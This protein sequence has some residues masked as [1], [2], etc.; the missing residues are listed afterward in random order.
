[1]KLQCRERVRSDL[2]SPARI[3]TPRERERELLGVGVRFG[4]FTELG[5][6]KLIF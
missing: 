3:V 6:W 2:L 1:M 5:V 4:V